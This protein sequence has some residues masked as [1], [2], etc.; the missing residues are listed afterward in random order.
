MGEKR[1]NTVE[2]MYPLDPLVNVMSDLRGDRGC[3]WDKEQ[4]HQ[5]IKQYLIEETYE[6]IEAI[7]KSDMDE[8]CSELGDVLLQ[9]IFHSQMASEKGYFDIN[10]VIRLV[11]NKMVRRH[12]HVFGDIR[13]AS[14]KDVA[15]NWEKIKEQEKSAEDKKSVLAGVPK[16]L[17]ALMK[18]YKLQAKAS[19]VGF[20]WPD[21]KGAK[22]KVDEELQELYNAIKSGD[23]NEISAELGDVLFAL[24]NLARLLD[25]NAEEA[26][27]TANERFKERFHYIE[28]KINKKGKLV[29]DVS[30]DEMNNLW[31]EA[32]NTKKIF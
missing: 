19:K 21:Y 7:D 23:N 18:A 6:V 30:L 11:T 27:H 32:K 25:I 13:V 31:E 28:E 9:V 17:P 29:T 14:S 8:L 3:P 5:S 2:C 10:D 24:V 22:N 15:E 4:T 26:L 20:D 12:P 1:N 16:S